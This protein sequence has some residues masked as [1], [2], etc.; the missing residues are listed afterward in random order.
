MTSSINSLNIQIWTVSVTGPTTA[1]IALTASR[2][3]YPRV[4]GQN[5][6]N[7]S[8]TPIRDARTSPR[9]R[10]VTPPCAGTSRAGRVTRPALTA[11]ARTTPAAAPAV[12]A[13]T[14]TPPVPP[15]ERPFERLEVDGHVLPFVSIPVG[16][17]S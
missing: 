2:L 6:R 15:A 8:R 1:K 14:A 4:A 10:P 13:A 12:G 3:R 16:R 7:I 9:L 11:R 5:V 17:A